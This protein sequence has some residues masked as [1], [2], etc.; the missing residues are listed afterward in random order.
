[1]PGGN[2]G[3]SRVWMGAQNKLQ[4]KAILSQKRIS[5]HKLVGEGGH[6]LGAEG[7]ATR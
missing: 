3:C 6:V 5:F 1:M 2:P 7:L 4:G